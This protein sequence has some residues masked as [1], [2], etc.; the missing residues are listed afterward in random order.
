MIGYCEAEDDG[1][2]EKVVD[3]YLIRGG[4]PADD[5]S[6]WLCEEHRP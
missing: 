2:A 6:L 1:A 5:R 3:L 4:T